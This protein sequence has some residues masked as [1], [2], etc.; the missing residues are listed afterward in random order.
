MSNLRLSHR[1]LQLKWKWIQ[2]LIV[3]LQIVTRNTFFKCFD[4]L[5]LGR[6]IISTTLASPRCPLLLW[7]LLSRNCFLLEGR[8]K[9]VAKNNPVKPPAKKGKKKV[10]ITEVS[11]PIVSGRFTKQVASLSDDGVLKIDGVEMIRYN[12]ATMDLINHLGIYRS[13]L[14]VHHRGYFYHG[15]DALHYILGAV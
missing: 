10:E 4:V 14:S 1:L 3:L 15:K 12:K 2:F 7:N 11:R 8:K 13:K 6:Q 5:T 9:R